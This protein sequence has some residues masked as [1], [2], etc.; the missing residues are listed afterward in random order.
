MTVVIPTCLPLARPVPSHCHSTADC[1]VTAYCTAS[2]KTHTY[3]RFFS[4]LQ[5]PP[6]PGVLT[7][8]PVYVTEGWVTTH[9][10]QMCSSPPHPPTIHRKP[11]SEVSV[12]TTALEAEW[13]NRGQIVLGTSAC[14]QGIL[15]TF[16]GQVTLEWSGGRRMSLF[17]WTFWNW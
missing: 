5:L 7:L 14:W 13:Q 15:N 11:F 1:C 17:F 4:D 12:A 3:P 9:T 16:S 2:V 10:Y 6:R 8:P